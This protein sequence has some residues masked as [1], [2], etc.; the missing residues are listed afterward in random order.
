MARLIWIT[1]GIFWAI[2]SLVLL[3]GA[4]YYEPVTLLDWTAVIAYTAA[5]VWLGLAIVCIGRLVPSRLVRIT[6]LSAA[7]PPIVA[8][9]ANLVEDGFDVAAASSVYV[10]GSLLTVVGLIALVAALVW[11]RAT[12]LA[13]LCVLVFAG[14]LFVAAGGGVVIL[15]AFEYLAGRTAW[16]VPTSGHAAD[17]PE[18]ANAYG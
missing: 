13:A 3:G 7:L 17:A 18:P 14:L 4:V 12:R 15:L 9:L 8:G 2:A 6:A 16:F 1:T 11:A 5:L 10:A